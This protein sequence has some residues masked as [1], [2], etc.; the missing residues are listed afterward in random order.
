[1][2]VDWVLKKIYVRIDHEIQEEASHADA[3][4]RRVLYLVAK[5]KKHLEDINVGT[6]VVT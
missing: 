5:P 1:M 2:Y 4:I 3:I 6:D